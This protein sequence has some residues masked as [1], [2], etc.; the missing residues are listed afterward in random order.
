MARNVA[1][2]TGRELRRF[3]TAVF[4][5][6]ELPVDWAAG[7]PS[8]SEPGYYYRPWKTI[9]TRTVADGGESHYVRGDH[10]RVIPALWQGLSSNHV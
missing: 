9:L 10:A 1:R 3:T 8:K 2:Q 5:I 4:D 6:V 7:P